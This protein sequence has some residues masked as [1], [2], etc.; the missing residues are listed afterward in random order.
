MSSHR[1]GPPLHSVLFSRSGYVDHFLQDSSYEE[2]L[3]FLPQSPATDTYV[4]AV[5]LV[6]DF[7]DMLTDPSASF[8]PDD[9]GSDF[10]DGDAFMDARQEATSMQTGGV[11]TTVPEILL[12]DSSACLMDLFTWPMFLCGTNTPKSMLPPSLVKIWLQSI[13]ALSVL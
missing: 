13:V 8:Y 4:F 12:G 11:V 3:G 2:L 9:A 6:D 10:G 5:A 1:D 7:R